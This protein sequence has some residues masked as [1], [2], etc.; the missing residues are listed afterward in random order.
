MC[1]PLGQRGWFA[2]THHKSK[3]SVCWPAKTQTKRGSTLLPTS[4]IS[5]CDVHI[6]A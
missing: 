3:G 1:D 6:K 2:W 5:E 4:T